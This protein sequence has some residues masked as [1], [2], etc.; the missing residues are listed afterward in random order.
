MSISFQPAKR[1]QDIQTIARMASDIWHEYWP[2]I[3]GEE[4]TD[5]MV[6]HFQSLE[7]FERDINENHYEYWFIVAHDDKTPAELISAEEGSARPQGTVVGY[8]GGHNEPETNR[9]FISKIYLYK[10]H[11][12][13]GY[14]SATIKFYT[15]LCKE[16]G[17]DAMYLTVNKHNEMGKRA[18]F[19]KG[20]EVIESVVNDIG[21]GF[22]MDDFIMEKRLK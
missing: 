7:A 10:E 1:A 17:F 22:V 16:R 4:Q 8:T 15:E 9:F 12:G 6:E 21:E 18:Y 2:A 11:R 14:A 5:Y 13:C 19:A 3:I 20:F